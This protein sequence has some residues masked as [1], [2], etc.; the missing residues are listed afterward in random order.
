VRTFRNLVWLLVLAGLLSLTA[1]AFERVKFAVISDPHLSLPAVNTENRVKMEDYSVE[2]FREAIEVV[3]S[4]HDLDF[5]L[6]LGDLTKDAEPW[7][8]DLLREMLEEV[9]FPVFAVLGNHEVS[10][11]PVK[12]REPSVASLV[13]SSKYTTVF[14]LQGYGFNGPRTYWYAEPIPGLLLVGL[15]TTKIGSW[16]GKVSQAQLQWLEGVLRANRDKLTIV[17]GHHL[18]VPFREEES[19]PEWKNF[20]LDNAEELIKLLEKHEQVSFYLCGHRHVST[21]PVE[22]NGI[23]YITHASTVTWPMS[24]TLYTLTPEKL[25]YE[26]IRLRAKPEVWDLARKTLLEDPWFSPRANASEEEI[27]AYYENKEYAR[28]SMPVRFKKKK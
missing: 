26:V 16:G 20:Y 1:F 22:R 25:E 8:I 23:W 17:L 27:L 10:P 19:K 2:L 21:V 15:D 9:K 6:L 12:G 3:N 28:F 14:A 4:I 7:N 11:I 24:I 13:G 18:L 5:V